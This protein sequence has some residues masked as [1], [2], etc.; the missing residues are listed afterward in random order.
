MS[1]R[2]L[3]SIAGFLGLLLAAAV[4]LLLAR[5]GYLETPEKPGF[6]FENLLL[7]APRGRR[8]ILRPMQQGAP[9]QRFWFGPIITE[10]ERDDAFDPAPH[11]RVGIEERDPETRKWI[12]RRVGSLDLALMGAMTTKEWLMEIRP[13]RDVAPDGTSRILLLASYGHESGATVSY[14]RDPAHLVPGFGWLRH[15]IYRAGN[16]PQVYYAIPV[17]AGE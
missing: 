1:T 6:L 13:V 11:L 5:L 14:L 9:E 3:A 17:P 10:P 15:E 4:V 8:V 7:T 16:P 2:A 12:Y